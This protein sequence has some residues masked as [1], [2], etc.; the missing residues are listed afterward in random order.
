MPLVAAVTLTL[1]APSSPAGAASVDG[2]ALNA[3]G[4]R[5][6]NVM[7]GWPDLTFT[8]EGL[9]KDKMSV[10][11]RLRVQIW[12]LSLSVGLHMRFTL[13]EKGRV[14]LALVVRPVANVAGFGG[15]RAVY[16]LN[17]QWGRTRTFRPSFGP[18]VNPGLLA[19]VDLS[20]RFRL[21][22]SLENPIAVWFWL[23]PVQWWVEWPIV[24]S[25]GVEYEISY[26]TSL[27]ARAGGGP[28]IAFAGFS[29]LLGINGH[30]S[31]GVQVRY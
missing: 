8:W 27:I 14:A 6:H 22:V 9:V 13:L 25:G 29:Q 17:Y 18:G 3:P 23:S 5:S 28:S 21:L 11:P 10:G 12:P 30:L 24:L 15:S 2:G 31:F 16:P 26:R 7:V 4:E 20:P 1:L 19:T